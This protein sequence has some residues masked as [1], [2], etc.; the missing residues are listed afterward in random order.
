VVG[1]NGSRP[2]HA[3]HPSGVPSATAL[4]YNGT[5]VVK[6]LACYPSPARIHGGAEYY[7][8]CRDFLSHYMLQGT[9]FWIPQH[10][11]SRESRMETPTLWLAFDSPC[12]VRRSRYLRSVLTK[13]VLLVVNMRDTGERLN[14][15]TSYEST[16]VHIQMLPRTVHAEVPIFNGEV[17]MA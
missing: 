3:G 13:A 10:S 17:G 9:V 4:L 14:G 15:V 8:S 5:K 11:A 1:Q 12:A 6:Y 7:T 2:V 16:L